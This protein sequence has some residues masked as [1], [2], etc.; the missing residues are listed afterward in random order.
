ML[1]YEKRGP[2]ISTIDKGYHREF[3]VKHDMSSRCVVTYI[4]T[5]AELHLNCQSDTSN[6]EAI[7]QILAVKWRPKIFL[8]TQSRKLLN[9]L[10]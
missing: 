5:G 7:S 8:H 6:T 1:P 10:S 2:P 3:L 9:R 4:M